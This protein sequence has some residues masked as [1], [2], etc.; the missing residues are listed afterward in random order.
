MTKNIRRKSSAQNSEPPLPLRKV[1]S[2]PESVKPYLGHFDEAP[3]YLQDNQHIKNGYRLNYSPKLILKS[4]FTVHNET[5][6]IWSHL[7]GFILIIFFMLEGISYN[8]ESS[9]AVTKF[10]ITNFSSISKQIN[11][12]LYSEA[13][14]QGKM[15]SW[16]LMMMLFGCALCL[17]CSATFHL[18][19]PL[20]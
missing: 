19:F 6:N 15:A 13:N 7:V 20:S 14:S 10:M 4:L 9:K 2:A 11:F 18:I 1:Q 5:G 3:Y 16:P 12:D 17:G 8:M